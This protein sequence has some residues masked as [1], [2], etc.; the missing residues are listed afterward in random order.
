MENANSNFVEFYNSIG[1]MPVRNDI[2]S[3]QFVTQRSF[4]YRSL[5]VPVN[6]M[7]G[8]KVLEFGPGGG[9]NATVLAQGS[10]MSEY[11]CIEA[12]QAGQVLIQDF[13]DKGLINAKRKVLVET[14]FLAFNSKESYDLVIAEGCIPGQVN[15]E[16]TLYHLQKFVKK[17]GILV[18]T[19]TTKSSLLS[20]ILRCC[21]AKIIR[22]EIPDEALYMEFLTAKFTQHLE[23]LRC[24]T[25]LVEDWIADV[26]L[27]AWFI[28]RADFSLFQASRI[29]KQ[30]EL[31]NTNPQL[32][33]DLSWYKT[34][35]ARRRN[36]VKL[37]K[38][39]EALINLLLLDTRLSVESVITM[40]VRDLNEVNSRVTSVYDSARDVLKSSNE[41]LDL[42]ALCEDL[43]KLIALD[44]T[45]TLPTYKPLL[46]FLAFCQ[47]KNKTKERMIEFSKWWGRGQQYASFVRF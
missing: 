11:W 30:F 27:Q 10:P 20:E 9:Y 35:T 18:I 41:V 44:V 12:S 28:R 5:G 1:T 47:S 40:E 8:M 42:G 37:L 16:Q 23:Q 7:G 14:D 46:E 36:R 2:T 24:N 19:T 22:N 45:P 26:I 38:E 43:T 33:T 31:V 25:R 3:K 15:P 13:F 6:F 34:Y 29:L 32:F 4:L 21:W 17:N 39:K